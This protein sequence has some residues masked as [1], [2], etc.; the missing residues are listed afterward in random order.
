MKGDQHDIKKRKDRQEERFYPLS[1]DLEDRAERIIR[2]FTKY[3]DWYER[4]RTAAANH[5]R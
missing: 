5:A 2:F 3:K 1:V 4:Q